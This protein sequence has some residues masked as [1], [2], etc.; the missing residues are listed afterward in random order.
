MSGPDQAATGIS[1]KRVAALL[2]ACDSRHRFVQFELVT[3]SLQT[4]SE[5]VDLLLL[6]HSDRLLNRDLPP[7]PGRNSSSSE[8]FPTRESPSLQ[9]AECTPRP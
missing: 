4:S 1:G 6:L 2:V 9:S 7:G 8:T 3:Y 5:C